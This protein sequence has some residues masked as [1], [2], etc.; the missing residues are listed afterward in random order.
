MKLTEINQNM[1]KKF[2]K[3]VKEVLTLS[4]KSDDLNNFISFLKNNEDKLC[5]NDINSKD[6]DLLIFA[7]NNKCSI[8]LI[9]YIIKNC[10]KYRKTL[11]YETEQGEIPL[12]SAFI[13]AIPEK[14]INDKSIFQLH[15]INLL[16]VNILV[17]NGANIN[18]SNK[19]GENLLIYLY[20][21]GLLNNYF[22]SILYNKRINVSYFLE[23]LYYSS[24]KN[25][26]D[27]CIEN[28]IENVNKNNNLITETDNF[29][30]K[31]DFNKYL[32][33]IINEYNKYMEEYILNLIQFSKNK[34]GISTSQIKNLFNNIK[35]NTIQIPLLF[36][37]ELIN[38]EKYEYI[39][40][41]KNNNIKLFNNKF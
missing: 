26:N 19:K 7:I 2:I 13:N 18:F 27:N 4:E 40:D 32:K 31:N 20:N 37:N 9:E 16:V 28:S 15:K 30:L 34:I 5:I 39:K 38:K 41:L 22:F 33:I 14:L 6:F 12:F 1:K 3:R 11:N 36:L 35:K 24:F 17:K 21:K 29:I 10:K 23:K 8:H 25:S